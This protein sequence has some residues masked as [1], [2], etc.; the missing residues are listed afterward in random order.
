MEEKS[1]A[2]LTP[3]NLLVNSEKL[4][5]KLIYGNPESGKQTSLGHLDD[6][7]TEFFLKLVFIATPE[8]SRR[9]LF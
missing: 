8:K 6:P 7:G 9:N 5:F 2:I 1:N 3:C 4:W